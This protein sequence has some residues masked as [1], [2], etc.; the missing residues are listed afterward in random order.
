MAPTQEGLVIQMSEHVPRSLFELRGKP[1]MYECVIASVHRVMR[2]GRPLENQAA[3]RRGAEEWVRARWWR[4]GPTS[5]PVHT[6]V[7]A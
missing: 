6:H 5:G 7:R 4:V 2:W 3:F 1:T